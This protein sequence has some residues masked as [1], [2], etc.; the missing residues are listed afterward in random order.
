MV[1]LISKK[2]HL[3]KNALF[4]VLLSILSNCAIALDNPDAP[5]LIGEFTKK[6]EPYL[7]AVN[8]P[9]NGSR[10]Y[11]I[12]YDNYLIFLDKELNS[13]YNLIKSKLPK[14]QQEELKASQLNWLKFRDAEF[15]LIKNTWT[16]KNF[17]SSA[18]ISRGSY[19][20]T[21]VKNRVLQLLYYAINF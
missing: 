1:T 14:E 3:Q 7:K 19:R 17:G 2:L 10:D 6:E 15:K 4:L 12:A 16:R 20:S 5:D 9:E 13:A 8:N 18:G 11:L 21:I